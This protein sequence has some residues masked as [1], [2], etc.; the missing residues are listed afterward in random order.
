M[1][2]VNK[3]RGGSILLFHKKIIGEGGRRTK[4]KFTLENL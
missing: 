4:G 2:W 1:V 3:G